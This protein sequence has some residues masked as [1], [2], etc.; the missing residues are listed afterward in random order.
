MLLRFI[1]LY[2]I[3]GTTLSFAY[4]RIYASA[5]NNV[6]KDV[7]S[8]NKLSHVKAMKVHKELLSEYVKRT[9]NEMKLGYWLDKNPN[10]PTTKEASK[11]YLKELRFLSHQNK[12]IN[13]YIKNTMLDTIYTDKPRSFHALLNTKHSLFTHDKELK[14][15]IKK[16]KKKLQKR[17][18]K[19]QKSISQRNK[20][21][22]KDKKKYY[23][24]A[25]YLNGTWIQKGET[26]TSF[27][28]KKNTLRIKTKNPHVMQEIKGTYKT[29][30]K[31]IVFFIKKIIRTDK[32][33]T[34]HERKTNVK[35]EITIV[36]AEP[37]KLLLSMNAES[38]HLLRKK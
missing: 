34:P 18:A 35:R 13:V 7:K 19:R 1:I 15:A 16:Y 27:I 29:T 8:I 10:M 28:F 37:K 12:N 26:L 32:E 5:S 23:R 24:S 3:I 9:N 2:L 22:Q 4:P 21:K 6:Y 25:R 33:G 38:Y 17:E 36:K 14:S 31:S 30:K 11:K 20:Q